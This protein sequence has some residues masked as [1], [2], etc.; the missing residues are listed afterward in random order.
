MA[1]VVVVIKVSLHGNLD[2]CCKGE[3]TDLPRNKFY[4]KIRS[5]AEKVLPC[6]VLR[7]WRPPKIFSSSSC[8]WRDAST[9]VQGLLEIEV[10]QI[11]AHAYV[12]CVDLADFHTNGFQKPYLNL[13]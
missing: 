6:V 9:G 8:G 12:W 7:I 5:L 3:R 11:K 2:G 13:E 4:V 10:P 1:V